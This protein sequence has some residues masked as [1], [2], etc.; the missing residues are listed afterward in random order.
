V[1]PCKIVCLC[2][3]LTCG[4]YAKE[5]CARPLIRLV[6]LRL[7]FRLAHRSLIVF[8]FFSH[9]LQLI[10]KHYNS[11]VICNI[12]FEICIRKYWYDR[13]ILLLVIIDIKSFMQIIY[14]D[15]YYLGFILYTNTYSTQVICIQTVN[16]TKLKNKV[17]ISFIKE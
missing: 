17:I 1:F 7:P 10:R 15:M 13:N 8:P 12:M 11:G 6:I 4:T 3:K 14:K 2:N 9:H 16:V 5:C